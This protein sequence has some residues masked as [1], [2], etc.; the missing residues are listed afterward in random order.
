MFVVLVK[1]PLGCEHENTHAMLVVLAAL[2]ASPVY[3]QT[4]IAGTWQG[5]L[6]VGKELRIV[7]TIANAEGGALRATMYS[8]DQGGQGMTVTP[9]VLEG[10]T[11]RMT[12]T[13]IGGT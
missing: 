2:F 1:F 8:I 10:T 6:N 7:F 11:V 3:A 5:T 12:I 4:T 9:V 13:G